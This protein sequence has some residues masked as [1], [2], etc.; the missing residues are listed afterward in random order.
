MHYLEQA[1]ATSKR[2]YDHFVSLHYLRLLRI[3]KYIGQYSKLLFPVPLRTGIMLPIQ[4]NIATFLH[5][6][7]LI[8]NFA[9]QQ[10]V[11]TIILEH[12]HGLKF[13]ELLN[14]HFQRAF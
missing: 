12:R 7:W 13:Q 2:I 1:F 6:P 11:A 9:F 14:E 10:E 4:S 5:G 8:L 3:A